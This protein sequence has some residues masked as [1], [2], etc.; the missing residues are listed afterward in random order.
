M[1]GLQR[2]VGLRWGMLVSNQAWQSLIK[3]GSLQSGMGVSDEACQGLRWIS[4][5]GCWSLMGLQL[6]SDKIIFLWTY[7]Q[8]KIKHELPINCS[9]II[10]FPSHFSR[11]YF[12][13]F[14]PKMQKKYLHFL[15]QSELKLG[16]RFLGWF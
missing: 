16:I 8:I 6:V 7:G 1:I 9:P 14:F 3:H 12:P 4:H 15:Q 5:Q 11:I 13:H 2:N 10:T